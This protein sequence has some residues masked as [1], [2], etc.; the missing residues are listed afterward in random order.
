MELLIS[1][2]WTLLCQCQNCKS[3]SVRNVAQTVEIF[4]YKITD[5]CFV[6][7][8]L[9]F[10]YGVKPSALKENVNYC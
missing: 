9:L 1:V 10:S 7:L 5:N 4:L 2:M 8:K 3:H 6:C